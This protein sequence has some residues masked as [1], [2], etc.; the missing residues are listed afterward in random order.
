M[1]KLKKLIFGLPDF[2]FPRRCPICDAPMR[3]SEKYVCSACIDK[4]K[5]ISGKTCAK[6]GRKM[7]EMWTH[8]CPECINADNAF[9]EAFAPFE[10]D[11]DIRTSIA[12]FKYRGRAEYALFYAKCICEYGEKRIRNWNADVIVPVPIHKS[13]LA[14]RGYNQAD[15]LAKELS[16]LIGIPIRDDL[17][18]RIKKTEAQKE[19]NAAQRKK[20]L[21]AAF[22]CEKGKSIPKAIIIADDI[23]TTGSTVNAISKLLKRHGAQR[24]YAVCISATACDIQP[25]MLS[26]HVV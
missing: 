18:K 21:A 13:R 12:R 19:L 23:F 20:N 3:K 8:V 14:E 25:R 10:Y 16:K 17:I 5:F 4:V 15:L 11:G 7:G 2:L 22:T 9:D 26:W 1:E 6:C 24:V